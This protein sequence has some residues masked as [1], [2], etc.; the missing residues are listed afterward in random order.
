MLAAARDCIYQRGYAATTARDIAESAGVSLAAIGYHFGSKDRLI[1]EALAAAIGDGIGDDLERLIR[2]A[3]TGRSL[4][5]AFAPTWAGIAT[6]FRRHREGMVAQA[7]NLIRLH[8]SSDERRY[9]ERMNE[10]AVTQIAAILGAV[11][12]DLSRAE[13]DAVAR[14]YFALLNGLSL[15]WLNDPDGGL[16]T[17]DDFA[18]ALRALTVGNRQRP[19]S[20]GAAD[21]GV[22]S[23][24]ADRPSSHRTR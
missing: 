6:I 5:E 3:G 1:T 7:E 11:H 9:V 14:L 10:E 18:T 12:P 17:G 2:S 20:A 13:A 8:R 4:A 15:Q 24:F 23:G 19:P 16:P 21:P 22:S